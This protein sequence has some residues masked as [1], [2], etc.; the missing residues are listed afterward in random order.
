M[1]AYF[2]FYE[3]SW[4]SWP[5]WSTMSSSSK[6][7]SSL[8]PDQQQNKMSDLSLGT[9][10]WEHQ[11]EAHSKE[12]QRQRQNK[13]FW[14]QLE[15]NKKEGMIQWGEEYLMLCLKVYNEPTK[16]P[17]SLLLC[18]CLELEGQP[19]TG[20]WGRSRERPEERVF[21]LFKGEILN[22]VVL[23]CSGQCLQVLRQRFLHTLT[24]PAL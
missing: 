6:T 1:L 15:W 22:G 4:G 12:K 23:V 11:G 7:S 5:R 18:P 19:A 3:F 16:G 13:N 14:A 9:L 8:F 21:W 2:S 24:T 10:N 20:V 17:E